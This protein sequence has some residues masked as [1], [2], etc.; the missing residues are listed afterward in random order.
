MRRLASLAILAALT[1]CASV[2]MATPEADRL[3]KEFRA[4]PGQTNLYVFRDESFGA[5]VKLGLVLDGRPL[6]ATAANTFLLTTVAPGKH[7]LVS[8]AENDS[9][10]EFVAEAGK[11]VY[12]WQEVKMGFLSA[13]SQLQLVDEASARP[14]VSACSLARSYDAPPPLPQPAPAK[15]PAAVPGI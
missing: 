11:N 12:V 9:L 13:R 15:A 10:L 4:A 14:R 7:A 2:P 5:A 6:G 8:S 1:A 3:A